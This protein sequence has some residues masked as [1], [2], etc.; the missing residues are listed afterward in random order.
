MS[1]FSTKLHILPVIVR[2]T[3]FYAVLILVRDKSFQT[4]VFN[5]S[6]YILLYP[7]ILGFEPVN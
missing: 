1:K 7:R 5:A 3:V 4:Y 6:E 2:K